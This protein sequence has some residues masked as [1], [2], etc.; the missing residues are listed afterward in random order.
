M[1][2]PASLPRIKAS[3]KYFSRGAEKVYLSGITYGPFKSGEDN[4]GLHGPELTMRDLELIRDMGANSVRLYHAPPGW[5]LDLCAKYQLHITV[6]LPW[7][8]H[9]DFLNER[10][11]Q[12]QVM[13][14]LGAE[15]KRL[16]SRPEIAALLVG[17]EINTTLVRWLGP[18]R[19][20]AFL[21]ELID[22]CKQAAPDTLVAYANYPSTEYLL[23][24]NADF[25][26]YNLYLEDR[27][28][29]KRYLARLQN[30]SGDRPLVI[31]EFGMDAR[32]HGEQLQ[33]ETLLWEQQVVAEAGAAGNFLF[34]FT[35]EWHRGGEEVLAWDFGLVD[36]LR[37]PKASYRALQASG[38]LQAPKS[39]LSDHPMV[40]VI[41]CTRNGSRTLEACLT[42]LEKIDYPN[43]EIIVVDDGSTDATPDII[44]AHPR[45]SSIPQEPAG[46]GVARN[47]G[48]NHARGTILAYTDDD[49]EADKDWLTYLMLAF[50]DPNVAAVGGPNIPP[51]PQNLAQASVIAAPGGPAHVLLNDTTAEHVPG[52]NLA[53][54]KSAFT[55]VGGFL[56]KYHAAGDDVDFCWRLMER[57]LVIAFHAGAMVWHHRRFTVGAYLKQQMGYGKAEGLLLSQHSHRFGHFGGARWRGIVY[58][59]TL[60]RLTR[61]GG[62]IYSGTFGHA[63]FQV[64]YS[65][66]FSDYF[67]ITSSF[68]WLLLTVALV[69][70]FSWNSMLGWVGVTMLLITLLLPLVQMRHMLI[71]ATYRGWRSKFILWFLMLAQPV[72]RGLYRFYWGVR[73]GGA[74]SGPW[75][76]PKPTR[77][78]RL[79]F[80]KRV[81]EFSFW[82]PDG[83]DRE[84]LIAVLTKHLTETRARFLTDDG[85][86]N[87]DVEINA[88]RWWSVRLTTVTEYHPSNGRLTR[89]RL[90]THARLLNV[91]TNLLLGCALVILIIAVPLKYS[92]LALGAFA[93][94]WA[95][96]EMAHRRTARRI[97]TL[98]LELG[99]S[100]GLEPRT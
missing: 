7:I 90:V 79:G 1:T 98:T 66:P 50:R 13:K 3:G 51:V 68:I 34:S 93:L 14:Q 31:S 86:R 19:V 21:E 47:T 89:V 9:V 12:Q 70:N 23:P 27:T 67:H 10:Q 29:L 87:W 22:T 25:A 5:F 99:S 69:A 8:D 15:A 78:A 92:I 56:P 44:A 55:E 39:A 4:G 58:Q 24:E 71:P 46:L 100:I 59:P 41:V 84:S 6:S 37:R 61:Q 88:S 38:P 36:R 32:T 74:P 80:P 94:W 62:R 53:V 65:A 97:A 43:F 26:A 82:H 28:A 57:G 63:P 30:L 73:S 35:D 77:L 2:E 81:A 16:S 54:R 33:A 91:F 60:L 48:A 83:K 49:C 85:W 96:L 45:I 17:N 76:N 42:S 40:S 52:C 20:L 11:T 72:V 64:I 75:V 18:R 95:I